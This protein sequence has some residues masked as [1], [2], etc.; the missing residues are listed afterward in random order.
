MLL[1]QWLCF[2][3]GNATSIWGQVWFVLFSLGGF[4][5]TSPISVDSSQSVLRLETKAGMLWSQRYAVFS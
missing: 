5:Q 2:L 1:S 4:A 3:S